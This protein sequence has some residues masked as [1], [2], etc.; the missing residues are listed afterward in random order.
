MLYRRSPSPSA[1]ICAPSLALRSLL[2]KD[3]AHPACPRMGCHRSH[4]CLPAL[5]ERPVG[6][7]DAGIN[8]HIRVVDE[9]HRRHR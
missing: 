9:E 7:R 3:T 4:A 8:R 5:I 2:E 1:R 6:N